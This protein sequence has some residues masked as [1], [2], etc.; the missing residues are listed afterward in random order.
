[1]WSQ[2][3]TDEEVDRQKAHHR[4]A[5]GVVVACPIVLA[6]LQLL[7]GPSTANPPPDKRGSLEAN[8][9]VPPPVSAMI[10]RSCSN[11]H[12]NETHW[13]WYARMAPAS[14]IMAKDVN[15][16]RRAMNLSRWS[17]QNGRRPD[18]AIATLTAAC[19]DLRTGRMPK[20][21]Y[22]LLHP[23]ATVSKTEADQFCGWATS[24][25]RALLRKKQQM[26]ARDT[27]LLS[28]IYK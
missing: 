19:E 24:E 2:Q 22:R 26:R 3:Q 6:L 11:C 23:E 17:T 16:A 9:A 18:L 8:F 1:M 15:E 4:I 25:V 21:N 27:K 20:W 28:A 5:R 12:S 7:P 10:E 14:W 13:P